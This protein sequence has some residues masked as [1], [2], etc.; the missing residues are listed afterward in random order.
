LRTLKSEIVA[1]LQ[2]D[3]LADLPHRDP[4]WLINGRW[5]LIQFAPHA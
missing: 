4:N 1:G 3:Q 5:G 2:P